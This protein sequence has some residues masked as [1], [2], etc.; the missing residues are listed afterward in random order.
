MMATCIHAQ[1]AKQA[2][3]LFNDKE[4]EQA[5]TAYQKLIK[6]APNNAGYNFFLGASMYE[7]GEKEEALPYLEKSAKRKYIN[8]YLYLGRLYFDLYRYD[9]AIENYETHIEWLE[10][11][12]RNTEDIEA[13]LDEARQY[14]RMLKGVEKVAVIDSFVVDKQNFLNAY[15]ISKETGKI[16]LNS[17]KNGTDF[18]NE[19]G[20]RKILTAPDNEGKMQLYNS[21]RL[22]NRWS[23]PEPIISINET[24]NV[25]FPFMMPDGMTL[26]FA[27]D[28]EGTLGGY[29]IY[30]T[31]YDSEDDE[32]LRPGNLGMPFNSKA[33]DYMMVIDEFNNLGWFAS[34]RNQ[35]EGKVCIYVFIPNEVKHTYNYENTDIEVI[36]NAAT[37]KEIKKTQEGIDTKAAKETLANMLKKKNEAEVKIDFYF[38]ITEKTMYHTLN[39]FKSAQARNAFQQLMQKGKDLKELKASLEAKREQYG[40][41]KDSE[42][43]KMTPS[44]LELERQIPKLEEE[45]EEMEIKVRAIEHQALK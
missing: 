13:E 8:A 18:E 31:R 45:Y 44:I 9:E 20:N 7:L 21:I 26:Y 30:V 37:L 19:V 34:D 11:K 23:E 42:K 17:Q 32:Y 29:D 33:N 39:D 16:T 14:I 28:E 40:I 25:N 43:E 38:P 3:K 4:Y 36:V 35:P 6:S 41:A 12:K 22:Q 5:K 1:T 10:E 15:R 24:G 27:S 2:E